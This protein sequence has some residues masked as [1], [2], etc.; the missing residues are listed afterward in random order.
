MKRTQELQQCITFYVDTPVSREATL[1][2]GWNGLFRLRFA[3]SALNRPA[4]L[5][6]GKRGFRARTANVLGPQPPLG[7][8]NRT[9]RLLGKDFGRRAAQPPYNT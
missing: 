5:P 2:R 6:D 8:L 4:L 1:S 3:E 7:T 9:F